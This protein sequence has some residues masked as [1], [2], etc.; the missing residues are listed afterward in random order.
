MDKHLQG[1]KAFGFLKSQQ[2]VKLNSINE[3]CCSS[4]YKCYYG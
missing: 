2:D 4:A 1:G 3:V